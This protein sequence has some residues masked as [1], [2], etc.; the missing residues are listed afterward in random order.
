MDSKKVPLIG[1]FF[2]HC[3]PLCARIK[4]K[5]IL[6]QEHLIEPLGL[7]PRARSVRS[8]SAPRRPVN[9]SMKGWASGSCIQ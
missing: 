8:S 3:C 2:I 5:R 1:V 7:R 9:S 6:N 4:I